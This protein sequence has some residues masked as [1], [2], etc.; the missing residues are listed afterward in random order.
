[1]TLEDKETVEAAR[2]AYNS[3]NNVQRGYMSQGC[4]KVLE[5]AETQ[6]D[7]LETAEKPRAMP[8]PNSISAPSQGQKD[9]GRV[10]E[11]PE[12]K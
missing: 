12:G 6:I 4:L 5:K 11:I 9:A 2:K 7:K 3:L 1:M 8:A 10:V